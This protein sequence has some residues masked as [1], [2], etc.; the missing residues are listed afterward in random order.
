MIV[1]ILLGIETMWF[2]DALSLARCEVVMQISS[3]NRREKLLPE[4]GNCN[5]RLGWSSSMH[6]IL[7]S[8]STSCLHCLLSLVFEA[9]C[10][11]IS[12][13]TAFVPWYQARKK[14]P[15]VLEPIGFSFILASSD[16]LSF[17]TA[18]VFLQ[19]FTVFQI[20]VKDSVKKRGWLC[21]E[22]LGRF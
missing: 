9:P 16:T 5:G 10:I 1:K 11:L 12:L 7:P 21:A 6:S 15:N 19:S 22:T 17:C 2:V 13:T 18:S 14:F 20:Q 3:V 4:T 8:C